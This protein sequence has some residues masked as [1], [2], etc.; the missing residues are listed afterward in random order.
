MEGLPFVVGDLCLRQGAVG[1][2]RLSFRHSRESG[3]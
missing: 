3:Y 1:V 2:A